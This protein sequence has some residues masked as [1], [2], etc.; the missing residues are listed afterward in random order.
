MSKRFE[1]QTVIVTGAA[2]GLG[3]GIA[4]AFIREGASVLAGDINGD[5][6]EQTVSELSQL[7]PDGARAIRINV[8]DADD[9]ERMVSDTLEWRGQIDHLVNNAGVVRIASLTSTT[10]TDWDQVIDVNLKGVFL[11]MRAVLPHMIERK[12]GSIVN[13]ASQAGKRGNLYIAPYCASK[14]GVIS[15][16]QTAALEAGPYVRVNCVCP[17]FI[18]TEL[19]EEEYDIVASITGKDREEIKLET[20]AA[21]PLGRFQEVQDVAD[22]ILF[23]SSPAASQTTGEA[24]NIS[25]GMVMD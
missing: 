2:R 19:Q 23:L 6:L 18:N 5:L 24:L 15:L 3:R 17:G 8:A 21:M 9:V 25:G 4:E 1:E 12:S 7:A 22:S 10:E 20:L 14:A 11:G 16:T 13:V